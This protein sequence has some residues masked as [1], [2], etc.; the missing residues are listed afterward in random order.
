MNDTLKNILI[1]CITTVF[2]VISI[3]SYNI[4]NNAK[5]IEAYDRCLA[6]QLEISKQNKYSTNFCYLK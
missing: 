3:I 6:T 2:I 4:Y 5:M 1:I